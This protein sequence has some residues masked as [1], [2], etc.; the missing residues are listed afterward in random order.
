[1]E[2]ANENMNDKLK[3]LMLGLLP[4]VML[5]GS[6][7][8]ASGAQIEVYFKQLRYMFDGIE[9]QPAANQ[10]KS[11]TTFMSSELPKLIK[12]IDLPKE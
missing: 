10:G 8:Y 1:M 5:A 4:G 12:K 7:A 3:G 9:K 11:F 6:A 2:R